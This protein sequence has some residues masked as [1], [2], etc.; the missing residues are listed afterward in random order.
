MDQYTTTKRCAAFPYCGECKCGR[1]PRAEEKARAEADVAQKV[2]AFFDN[3]ISDN[4][5]KGMLKYINM[6]ALRDDF[7]IAAI[8]VIDEAKNISDLNKRLS[9]IY[10]STYKIP[11]EFPRVTDGNVS[12]VIREFILEMV[13]GRLVPVY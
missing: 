7:I 12:E 2:G 4:Y 3:L 11:F 9:C 8:K 1:P 6:A 5:R 13:L 10:A